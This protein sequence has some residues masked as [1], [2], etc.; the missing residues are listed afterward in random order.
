L[1]Y[2]TCYRIPCIP[3]SAIY[4]FSTHFGAFCRA[5]LN[6]NWQDL[7]FIKKYR[8]SNLSQKGKPREE[9]KQTVKESSNQGRN[10]TLEKAFC[11]TSHCKLNQCHL[12][13]QQ[14][15]ST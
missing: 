4:G 8:G 1:P 12:I 10:T 9:R 11:R 13:Y 7:L 6:V 15:T 14:P 3:K 2:A 5:F